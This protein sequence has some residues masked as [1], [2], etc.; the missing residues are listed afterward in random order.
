MSAR[1]CSAPCRSCSA[2][3]RSRLACL[4]C[5]SRIRGA[6]YDACSESTSVSAVNPLLALSKRTVP[7]AREFQAIQT[8][9][10]TVSQM[11]KRGVPRNRATP[12]ETRPAASL[13][14]GGRGSS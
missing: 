4:F 5:A 7:G 14:R 2:W 6:A 11:M 10:N 12:S 13:L 9:Q 3:T 8:M 1:F